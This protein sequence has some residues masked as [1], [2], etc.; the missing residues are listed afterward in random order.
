MKTLIAFLFLGLNF[1]V[2]NHL[3]SEEIHPPR[4]SLEQFPLQLGDWRC[5]QRESIEQK[6][7][8]NLGVTDYLVCT[9][10]H[11]ELMPV[12]V[13]V[14]YHRSQVNKE[15]GAGGE[16]RI[17]PPA[18]C[19]PGSGWDIIASRNQPLAIAGLP[20]AGAEAKRLIIAKGENRQ[21]VYYWYQE[22]GRV[23]ADDWR[24]IVDLFWDRARLSRTDG[25]L[26]RL[27][28]PIARGDEARAEQAFQSFA[29]SL[30]PQLPT[31]VPN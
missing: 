18:H 13:Y 31:Y 8:K 30:V 12:G 5:S 15:E 29:S 27:T 6:M 3:A 19:L 4:R 20:Q 22:R 1:Y 16:S 24:K 11:A 9:Y 10:T 7:V 23:I 28:V 21:L 17:H 2:Y 26:V 14:G 25:A